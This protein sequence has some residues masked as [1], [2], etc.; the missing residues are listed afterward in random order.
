MAEFCIA[1][2]YMVQNRHLKEP[3][4][5]VLLTT[6]YVCKCCAELLNYFQQCL[7]VCD[8]CNDVSSRLM[9]TQ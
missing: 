8:R 1:S 5:F 6:K 7:H 3:V 4:R 9:K 2:S